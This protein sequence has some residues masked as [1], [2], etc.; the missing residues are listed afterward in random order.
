[1]WSR[2]WGTHPNGS[3][4]TPGA[5]PWAFRAFSTHSIASAASVFCQK[6]PSALARLVPSFAGAPASRAPTSMPHTPRVSVP[7]SF[8]EWT[9]R[10]MA[11][12]VIGSRTQNSWIHSM[13]RET[14]CVHTT[15]MP[16]SRA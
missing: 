15:P 1:M 13:Y 12:S 4:V 11:A 3:N 2:T 14:S 16:L 5:R 6:P 10:V 8:A 7:Q 9:T